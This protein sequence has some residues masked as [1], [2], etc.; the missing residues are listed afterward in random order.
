MKISIIIVAYNR[1]GDLNDCLNSILIQSCLPYEVIIVDNSTNKQVKELAVKKKGEFIKNNILLKYIKNEKENSLTLAR[2]IGTRN[3]AGKII[4][5]LDDDIIADRNYLKE[6]IKTYNNHPDILGVHGYIVQEK[7]TKIRNF[8]YKSFFLYHLAENRCQ[9]LPSTC[10]VYPFEP[11]KIISCQWLPGAST[12]KKSIFQEF[13]FD[14]N[15]KKYSDGEDLEFSYRVFKKYPNSLYITPYARLIHKA[16]PAGRTI[17]KELILM[18]EVYSLY[19]F[20]KLIPQTIKNKIIYLWSRI[21]KIILNIVSSIFK[22]SLNGII[23][24]FYIVKAY[25]YCLKHWEEI[26]KAKLEFFNNTLENK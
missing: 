3:A 18:R 15:L 12:Y 23:E 4:C 2:N 21:G 11:K 7:L 22:L 24:N 25:I 9:V 10:V 1:P 14:E 16:S 5:F 26:K 6:I 17:G 19:L 20:Y 8:L 13:S